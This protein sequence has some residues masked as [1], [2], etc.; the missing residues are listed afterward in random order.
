MRHTAVYTAT[1]HDTGLEV[2]FA[3]EG[4]RHFNR[5]ES[6]GYVGVLSGVVFG[7]AGRIKVG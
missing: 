6:V 1:F 2:Q 3:A 5:C 7:L 4:T